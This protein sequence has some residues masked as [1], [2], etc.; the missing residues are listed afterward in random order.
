MLR[1]CQKVKI[2]LGE[3]FVTFLKRERLIS[4]KG[5]KRKT[6]EHRGTLPDIF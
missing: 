3:F 1:S 6:D 5:G 2:K 4:E